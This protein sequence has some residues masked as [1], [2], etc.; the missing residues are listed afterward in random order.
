MTVTDNQLILAA[1][2]GIAGI[3]AAYMPFMGVLTKHFMG[4]KD[5]DGTSIWSFLFTAIIAQFL[6]AVFFYWVILLLDSVNKIAGMK[7]LGPDGAF[8]LFWKVPVID[9]TTSAQVW[10]STIDMIRTVTITFNAFIP[11]IAILG[12][13]IAGYSV[14]AKQM[15]SRGTS[16]NNDDY[17]NYGIK[18]FIGAFVAAIVYTGW[19]QMASYTMQIPS[20]IEGKNT[21]LIE[22]AQSWWRKSLGVKHGSDSAVIKF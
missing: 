9:S 17:F 16:D 3:A 22:A 19:A 13:V 12:G 1:V 18:M 7:L 20:A 5:N 8:N 15:H 2:C 4:E 10:T 6:V 14:A 21:T 11:V